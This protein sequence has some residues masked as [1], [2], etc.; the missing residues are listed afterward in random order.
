MHRPVA[1]LL[2]FT[3][4]LIGCGTV[5]RVGVSGTADASASARGFAIARDPERGD[6]SICHALPGL[7]SRFQGDVGPP[8]HGVG[9]RLDRA[10]LR[11]WLV[12]PRISN[13]ATIMPAYGVP[14]SA[15]PA[16]DV[17]PEHLGEPILTAAEIDAVAAWLATLTDPRGA[18][19][20]RP[21]VV[22]PLPTSGIAWQGDQVRGLQAD[23][24]A[25][26]ATLWLDEGRRLWEAAPAGAGSSCSDC[27]GPAE[28]LRGLAARL[29]RVDA[30]TGAIETLE[31]LI[32]RC[33]TTRQ[34]AAPW[35]W[36]SEPLL[37]MATLL[38]HVSHGVPIDIRIDSTAAA[39]ALDRGRRL[40]ETRRGQLGIS[41]AQ[42]HVQNVGARLRGDVI[43]QGMVDGFPIYRLTWQTMG[44]RPRMLRWCSRAVR[45]TPFEWGS[46]DAAALEFWLARRAQG[47]PI[48]TPAVRR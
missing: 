33:R 43:S 7:D 15:E 37:A 38:S 35:D 25:S 9:A 4:L 36:E 29:P 22:H 16:R 21:R 28:S 31:R 6:C 12:N 47:L 18:P 13:P 23:T 19:P 39:R 1:T 10:Q 24:F 48:S 27:H 3:A 32:R 2:L 20:P 14:A 41:C 8:L 34:A 17:A 26:P 11:A 40:Y 30:D 42:C 45:A 44:S 46:D 5:P